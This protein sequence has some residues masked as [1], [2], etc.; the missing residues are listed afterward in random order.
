[1]FCSPTFLHS[2]SVPLCEGGSACVW[3]AGVCGHDIVRPLLNSYSRG[4][5]RMQQGVFLCHRI[6][7]R[8]FTEQ[9]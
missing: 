8:H 1:M 9:C 7:G 3:H 2:V 6:S 5:N 4:V